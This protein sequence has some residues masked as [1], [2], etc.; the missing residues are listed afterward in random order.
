MALTK[1]G[2]NKWRVTASV[3][4]KNKGYPVSKQ[5]TITGTR[6]EA[7]IV[8]GDILKE[9][10]AR[11]LTSAYAST[12]GE[13][14]DLYVNNLRLRGT[15]AKKHEMNIAH[16]RDELGHIRLEAFADQ[17]DVWYKHLVSTP[18]RY[19]K[20]RAGATVNR[21]TAVV[22]AVFSRL[23]DLEIIDKNPIT[24]IRYPKMKEKAR[25][26]YLSQEERLRLLSAIA[27][28]R[29]YI[30]P[31]VQFMMAVP[32]R[33]SELVSAKRE[34]FNPFTRTI[35]IPD[36]KADIPVH[37]PVP[38]DM[39]DYFQNIPEGCPWLFYEETGV[40]KVQYRPLTHLRYAW[41]YCLKKAGI[42]DVHVHDL[43]HISA[44]D[45]YAAGIPE[46][47]IMDVA[48]WKS[49]MLSRYRHADSLKSAQSIRA[50][51]VP[52]NLNPAVKLAV[53]S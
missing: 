19:G 46:R 27:E 14:V 12:F 15:L 28:H 10:K 47:V 8:E 53:S 43:R 26:R 13:A 37:K 25:D 31:I 2:P 44:T 16:I 42:E 52:E 32:C 1:I 35:F 4:D 39:M 51:W 38:D 41:R 23:V 18:G 45:L 29:P 40:R 36:T 9:L 24:P 21:Y 5:V 20:P 48:G 11:S 3:W 34:Q 17:F 33:V 30:L 6:A 49:Q 7:A 22:R 50:F